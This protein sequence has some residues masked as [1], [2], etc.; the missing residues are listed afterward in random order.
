M[1]SISENALKTMLLA[2]IKFV[3]KTTIE[4]AM[5]CVSVVDALVEVANSD[6]QQWDAAIKEV[7][8]EQQRQRELEAAKNAASGREHEDSPNLTRQT[9]KAADFLVSKMESLNASLESSKLA[10]NFSKF[11]QRA[12]ENVNE[13]RQQVNASGDSSRYTNA[14]DSSTGGDDITNNQS[15]MGTPTPKVSTP[16]LLGKMMS[17]AAGTPRESKH[18]VK[19]KEEAARVDQENQKLMEMKRSLRELLMER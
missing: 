6:A 3:E 9:S 17:N 16:T 13:F 11:K 2:W 4:I 19:L 15:L 7:M 12:K 5:H 8:K 1:Q 18:L 14:E 10:Q